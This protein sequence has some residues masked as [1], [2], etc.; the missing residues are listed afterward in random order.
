MENKLI[1][2][3][4]KLQ[5]AKN[6]D[7]IE[8]ICF[9]INSL[10]G[11]KIN[12]PR[13]FLLPEMLPYL[14]LGLDINTHPSVISLTLKNIGVLAKLSTEETCSFLLHNKLV[15]PIFK[16]ITLD[17]ISVSSSSSSLLAKILSVRNKGTDK[18]I[19]AIRKPFIELLVQQQQGDGNIVFRLLDLGSSVLIHQYRNE[20]M[21]NLDTDSY[22]LE[23]SNIDELESH[24]TADA[25][26]FKEIYLKTL[27]DSINKGDELIE[28]NAIEI[29]Q[30]ICSKAYGIKLMDKEGIF[31]KLYQQLND[32]VLKPKD[33]QTL[34]RSLVFNKIIQV[35]CS[36]ASSGG[37]LACLFIF[38]NNDWM[39]I[40]QYH[41]VNSG[42]LDI[43]KRLLEKIIS[44][45]GPLGALN[46]GIQ[47]LINHQP[48]IQNYAE[49]ILSNDTTISIATM[50]S[51]SLMLD[52]LDK[53]SSN[54][55]KYL[56]IYNYIPNSI[57][58]SKI[59][60][61]LTNPIDEV[62][63]STLMLVNS[64][65]MHS[66]GAADMIKVPGLLEYLLNRLNENTKLFREW[67]FTII[68]TL[69]KYQ[70]PLFQ[71]T[72]EERNRFLEL[73]AYIAKG[74]HYIPSE[75][76]VEIAT[77]DA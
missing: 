15:D 44:S 18:F 10:I 48:L 7:E 69:V 64:L 26:K 24:F 6:E 35:I 9:E 17:S 19:E 65:C 5:N 29:V 8:D 21:I 74:I 31:S 32:S 63:S 1:E 76:K 28:M 42:E 16:L 60:K 37:D 67:K 23:Q 62:K 77:Q 55:D 68:S 22:I 27:E 57:F 50:I 20:S 56:Q 45:I 52:N 25:V 2:Q 53:N 40:F 13:L 61:N 75:A 36:I 38:K 14:Q 46:N 49:L 39:A 73:K 70:Q 54:S 12:A 47:F 4:N 71:S 41:L 43:S 34:H 66:W 72:A 59:V 58:I 30:N 3:F 11:T 33:T 51:F